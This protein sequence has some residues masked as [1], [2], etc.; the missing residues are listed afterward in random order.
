MALILGLDLGAR[1]VGWALLEKQG[2][3]WKRIVAAGVR[4]FEAG[5]EGDIEGGRDESRGAARRARRL[6]RR[7]VRRR[8]QR[9]R[10]LY[11]ELAK[12]GLLPEAD[13][14]SGRPMALCIQQRI[15]QLDE[16]LR[17]K[18]AGAPGVQ[19]IPY[20]LRARALD[21]PLEPYELGRALYHLGQRRGFKSNRKAEARKTTIEDLTKAREEKS[22]VYRGIGDLR[23]AM[24]SSGAR[25][26]G[27]YLSRLNPAEERIRNRYTHR[28]MYEDEFRKIW[29]AQRI[30]HP[31]LT[32]ELKDRLWEILFRQRP[33]RDTEDLIGECEWIPG[34]KRAPLWS[35]D[36]QRFRLLQAVNHLRVS[37]NGRSPRPLNESERRRLVEALDSEAKVS[38]AQAKKILGLRKAEFTLEEGGEKHLPGN[39]VGAQLAEILGD[40]W[41]ALGFDQQRELVNCIATAESDE[42]LQSTLCQK[43]VFSQTVAGKIA[44]GVAL[45]SGYA[46]LSLKAIQAVLPYL[47]QG[48]SVQE[49]RLRAGIPLERRVDVHAFLPP[50]VDS[51]VPVYSPAVKRALTEMR[52]VVNAIIRRYGKPDEI[53]IETARELRK[54]REERSKDAKR[55]REREQEREK[56]RQRIHT[57]IGI[58]LHQIARYDI[59]TGLLWDE[60]EGRCPYCGESLGG[61]ASLFGGNSPAQIEH[62]I[63]FS[64]SLDNSQVNL[65]LAHVR[66]N[67]EKGDRTPWEA[68]GADPERWEQ[69]LRRVDT[70]KGSLARAKRN[71]FRMDENAVSDLLAQFSSRHLNDTRAAAVAAARY[72]A[73]LY[74]GEIVEGERKIFKLTGQVTAYLRDVWELNGLIPSIHNEARGESSAEQAAA[75]KSRDD[76]RHHA[77]DAVVIALCNQRWIQL[78]SEANRGAAAARRRLFAPIA[79]PWVGFKEELREILKSM[80]ISF[81]PDHRVTGA[82]H[83]ETFYTRVGESPE[84]GDVVRQRKPVTDLSAS[85]IERIADPVVR[86]A[87]RARFEEV[88]RDA[89]KLEGN[90]PVLPNRNGPPVPIKRVRIELNRAVVPVGRGFWLRWAEPSETHH[91]EIYEVTGNGRTVW[92]GDVVSMREAVM[93]AARGA[94]VVS[95]QAIPNARFLFS[96]A[97]EDTVRLRGDREGIWVVKKIKAD[98]QIVLVPQHDARKEKDKTSRRTEFAPTAGGLQKYRAEKVVVLPIGDVVACHE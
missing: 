50:L 24:E 90:W 26:L 87:V 41:K 89:R 81:R 77:I 28:S 91:I 1:S 40:D 42:Q 44:T 33:L 13:A 71:R 62:I 19:Q 55:M 47:E 22:K 84:G 64:R 95:R 86:E 74:G 35:L 36:Y 51:G 39:V 56:M 65:T 15:N 66:C 78:L 79:P 3:E 18:Y 11:R 52:K 98:T 37:V 8:R 21:H 82:L 83:K 29:E 72:L 70:F 16:Q 45:P 32:R 63:P 67:R 75:I 25:T 10:A 23:A 61:F 96:L 69:I 60:C 5:T 46:S 12:A 97:K 20:L 94:P 88:G 92:R 54:S 59:L 85:E 76:H 2:D 48:L 73:L 34:E 30:H 6:A 58:P 7:Q 49:A 4:V 53:H 14:G 43:W 80:N 9:A 31:A 93:R 68:Y 57:E 17:L 38:V 27:E